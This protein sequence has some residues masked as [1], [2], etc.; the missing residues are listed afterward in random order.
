MQTV[1]SRTDPDSLG[2]EQQRKLKHMKFNAL[3]IKDLA[4]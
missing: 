3:D 2:I 4:T 1:K